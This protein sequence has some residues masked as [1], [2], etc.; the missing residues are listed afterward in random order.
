MWRSSGFAIIFLV[1]TP[2]SMLMTEIPLIAINTSTISPARLD[3]ILSMKRSLIGLYFSTGN[4][5][6]AVARGLRM[7]IVCAVVDDYRFAN[8]LGKHKS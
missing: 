2:I 5:V 6:A 3:I 8:N 7:E 4:L 1:F